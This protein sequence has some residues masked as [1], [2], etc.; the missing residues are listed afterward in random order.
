MIT[1]TR[2]RKFIEYF[3]IVRYWFVTEYFPVL[4]E[5]DIFTNNPI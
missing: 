3:V 4:L 2:A 5:A 1:G